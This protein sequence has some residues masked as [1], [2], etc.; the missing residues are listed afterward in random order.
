MSASLQCPACGKGTKHN[1]WPMSQWGERLTDHEL[2]RG[3]DVDDLRSSCYDG[4][5]PHRDYYECECG[6]AVWLERKQTEPGDEGGGRWFLRVCIP[7]DAARDNRLWTMPNVQRLH[8][9]FIDLPKKANGY[10]A[11]IVGC[12]CGW[13]R[14]HER[15]RE[16]DGDEEWALHA[17]E[18]AAVMGRAS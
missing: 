16:R 14:E 6:Q 2:D 13:L 15:E 12:T 1:S 3:G 18:V 5:L 11:R 4:S 10:H 8:A 9:P 7:T 17:A